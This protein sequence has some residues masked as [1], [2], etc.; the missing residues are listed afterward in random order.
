[1]RTVC[2]TCK[3]EEECPYGA[4]PTNCPEVDL[5]DMGYEQAEIDAYN[6]LVNN[7]HYLTCKEEFDIESFLKDFKKAMEI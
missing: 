4:Q 7:A 5:Y 3:W 2:K 6:W 1:M